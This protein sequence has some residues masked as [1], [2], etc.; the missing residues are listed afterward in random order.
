M[1]FHRNFHRVGVCESFLSTD[2]SLSLYSFSGYKV[3]V[4]NRASMSRGGIAFLAK[5]GIG[6]SV[7]DDLSIV[8]KIR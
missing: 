8:M 4:K 2:H 6:Y 3:Q 1:I 7:R 5:E